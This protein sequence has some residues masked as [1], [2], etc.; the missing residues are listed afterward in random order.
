MVK[1]EYR[2]EA[3]TDRGDKKKSDLELRIGRRLSN[4]G[5]NLFP[6][7]EELGLEGWELIQVVVVEE[8][9]YSNL[10]ELIFKRP[11]IS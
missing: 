6:I 11:I 7:V 10:W 3:I 2:S 9:E 4:F 1:W 5:Y 8:L